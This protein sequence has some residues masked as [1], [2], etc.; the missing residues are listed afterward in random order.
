MPGLSGVELLK[1]VQ[2][3][4]LNTP[5][6]LISGRDSGQDR[7]FL[8]SLGAFAFVRKPFKLE[9]IEALINQALKAA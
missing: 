1:R 2:L 5:V 6:I 7:D 4:D 8:L 9:K 3:R